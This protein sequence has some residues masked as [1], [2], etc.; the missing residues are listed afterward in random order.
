[1]ESKEV[2]R[3]RS[4]NDEV[5]APTLL[6]SKIR[7]DESL[8][9]L[10]RKGLDQW[11]HNAKMQSFTRSIVSSASR[12]KFTFCQFVM[13]VEL[14]ECQTPVLPPQAYKSHQSDRQSPSQ[15]TKTSCKKP[16]DPSPAQ[17]DPNF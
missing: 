15:P 10:L 14:L 8:V 2:V 13:P 11:A 4:Q 16:T 9:L 7:D 17:V 12:K 6:L 1:M 5:C 3:K